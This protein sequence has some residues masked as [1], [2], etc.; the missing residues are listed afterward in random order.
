LLYNT[1]LIVETSPAH[2]E[3]SVPVNNGIM[4]R[5]ST[6]VTNVSKDTLF[7]R[8]VNGE[9]IESIVTYDATTR[10]AYLKPIAPL[11]AGRQYQFTVLGG[12]SGVKT[13]IDKTLPESKRYEFT[14]TSDVLITAPKNLKVVNNSGHLTLSWLQPDQFDVNKDLTYKVA[15]STSALDPESDSG[16]VIWPLVADS[17][18]DPALTSIGV[19]RHL[20]PATYYAYVQAY[21]GTELGTWAQTQFVVEAPVVTGGGSSGG[22]PSGLTFE[23][24][25]TYPKANAAHI[26]PST[27]KVLFSSNLDMTTVTN[28]SVYL[29]KKSKPS[30]LSIIDLMT[31]YAPGGVV[32]TIDPL[33]QANLLSVTVDP[34]LLQ[35][36]SEYTMIIRESVKDT[37]GNALG[38]AYF[39]SFNTTFVPLYGNVELIREDIKTLLTNIPDKTVYSYM[40]TVSQTAL[41][42]VIST[43]GLT[44]VQIDANVPRYLHEYV[45]AQTTYDLLVS[46]ILE[47][48]SSAGS[49]RTLGELSIDNSRSNFKAGEILAGFKDRIKPWLDELHGHHNRG[50]AKPTVT[51]RGENIEPY[52]TEFDRKTLKDI[53]A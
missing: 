41:D 5:F 26:L 16:A 40:Q 10:K 2:N 1:F 35:T 43:Q 51:V 33:V 11:E 21:I 53:N 44:Q 28:Q 45:R 22:A 15:I 13:A 8:K 9:A 50:Y 34:A 37:S 14:T 32:V 42:I 49:V 4:V 38:E 36:N 18:E 6:D 29:L 30:S 20:E 52:P 46:A 12:D 25:E 48:S 39:W 24:V 3:M 19:S 7:L 27:I 17:I 47:K 31:D 23:I